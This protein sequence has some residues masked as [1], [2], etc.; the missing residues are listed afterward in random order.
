MIIPKPV[1][2]LFSLIVFISCN[3]PENNDQTQEHPGERNLEPARDFPMLYQQLLG[4]HGGLSTWKQYKRLEFDMNAA[5]GNNTTV[6]H[7]IIDLDNRYERI[8]YDDY[9][10]GYD[11]DTYWYYADSIPEDHPNPEFYINLQFYF[12]MLPFV[13]ADPGT[14]YEIL[15][16]RNLEGKMYEVLKVTYEDGVGVAPKDQYLLYIDPE[17]YELELLLYSVTYFNAEN[18]ESYNALRYE[19]WQSA[20]GLLI[21][22]KM[23]NYRWDQENQRL[24]QERGYKEFTNVKFSQVPP[25]K[26]LFDMPEGAEEV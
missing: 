19:E 18:A 3:A 17:T 16:P 13:I 2:L 4:A 9:E 1:Y 26:E 23:V 10:M 14:N 12:F 22:K 25:Q 8:M 5:L 7:S 15:E 21:P 20:Q 24:G 11:G 6:Q